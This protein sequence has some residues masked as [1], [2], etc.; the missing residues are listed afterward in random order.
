MTQGRV[1]YRYFGHARVRSPCAGE[2][3]SSGRVSPLHRVAGVGEQVAGHC[4]AVIREAVDGQVRPGPRDGSVELG[5]DAAYAAGRV[6]GEDR[7]AFAAVYTR[8]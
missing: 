3:V 2:L 7:D 8:C 1:V 5:Q 4:I 6:A